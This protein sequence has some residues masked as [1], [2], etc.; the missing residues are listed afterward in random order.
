MSDPVVLWRPHTGPQSRFLA[1][2]AYEALYGGAAG[3]GKS[4]ALLFGGLRQI[5][6]P[7]Y[8]ALILRRTFPELRELMDRSLAFFSSIG[9][10]WNEQG[11]RWTF[12]SG[13]TYEFGYC[14]TYPDVFRYQGQQYTYIAFDELGQV[15]EERIWTYLMSRNRAAAPN[16]VKQMRASANPGGPGHQWIKRR[17]ISQCD[18]KGGL[19]SVML[20]DDTQVTRAFFQALLKDNPTLLEHDPAYGARLRLLPDLEY[21]WLAEGDWNAG[22]GLGLSDLNKLV[23]WVQPLRE[24]PEHWL[25]FGGFDWG[26]AHPFSFGLYVADDQ[27]GVYL[28]DSVSGRH[29]Q[30]PEIVDRIA[31]TILPLGVS[32]SMLKYT[33][34]G[35]DCWADVK[36][37]AENIP[38]VAE[39]FHRLGLPLTRANIS[40]ITGVQNIR[41][42]IAFKTPDGKLFTPRFHVCDTSGNARTWEVLESRVSDPDNPEDILKTNADDNGQGGDDPYDQ[43]RYALA[44]RPIAGK[45]PSEP[46]VKIADR[47]EPL[48]IENGKLKKTERPPKTIEDLVEWA[49]KRRTAGRVPSQQRVPRRP[50]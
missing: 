30:P 31:Q 42:Y 14:E 49:A 28:L 7:S 25:L 21:K 13:A 18:A 19:T 9:G 50:K 32:V 16:L 15:A 40:R 39:H 43:V 41:R 20:D 22:A 46:H 26:Y 33:V 17:F 3:G 44:S 23:H 8:K 5:A 4:D 29:L 1:S 36:A 27:G 35:H 37:R 34:A 48:H 10:V 24:I 47:A 45:A 2:N 12:P 38:T 6:H 11:K